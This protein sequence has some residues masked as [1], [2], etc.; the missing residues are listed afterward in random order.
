M[1]NDTYT[2]LAPTGVRR[3]EDLKWRMTHIRVSPRRTSAGTQTR[4][5]E[6][7]MAE[8]MTKSHGLHVKQYKKDLISG[9]HHILFLNHLNLLGTAKE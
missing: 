1:T 4:S 3:D 5:A 9:L 7:R 8:V 6:G 2:G